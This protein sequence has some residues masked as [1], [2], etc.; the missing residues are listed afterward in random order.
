MIFLDICWEERALTLFVVIDDSTI[1][2]KK[3]IALKG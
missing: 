1:R 3:Y 2:G